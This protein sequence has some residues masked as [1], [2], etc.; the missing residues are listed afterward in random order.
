M[1]RMLFQTPKVTSTKEFSIPIHS[2]MFIF[3]RQHLHDFEEK[4]LTR[5]EGFFHRTVKNETSI[6]EFSIQGA[7]ISNSQDSSCSKAKK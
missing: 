6:K 5:S 4:K 3:K 7:I 2:Y 1:I